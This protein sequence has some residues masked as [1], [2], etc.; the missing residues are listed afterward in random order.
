MRIALVEEA[1]KVMLTAVSMQQHQVE[2]SAAIIDHP[3]HLFQLPLYSREGRR[4]LIP[5]CF[6]SQ[7]TEADDI[8]QF[9]RMHCVAD[10]KARVNLS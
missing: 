4:H 8:Q 7:G 2:F 6:S 5:D 10:L 3:C 9:K 1:R